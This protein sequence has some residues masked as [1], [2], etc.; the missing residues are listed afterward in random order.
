MLFLIF[1]D[2][3]E[4]LGHLLLTLLFMRVILQSE[5]RKDKKYYGFLIIVIIT[6]FLIGIQD[7]NRI[8]YLTILSL[9]NF[10]IIAVCFKGNF[11]RNGMIYFV[12]EM[13]WFMVDSFFTRILDSYKDTQASIGWEWN[14]GSICITLIKILFILLI[15]FY[16][17]KKRKEKVWSNMITRLPL[18]YY[19]I[20][21]SFLFFS[22]LSVITV[23]INEGVYGNQSL[24][25]LMAVSVGIL[26]LIFLVNG[27]V[28]VL[29]NASRCF[30]QQQN[31][32]KDEYIH[33]QNQF[34][35]EIYEG[36][37]EMR[38]FRH[39][40][41]AHI[42][43]MKKLLFDRK[44]KELED[45]MTSL[46]SNVQKTI[47]HKINSKNEM[48]DAI[49]NHLIARGGEEGVPIYILG[50]FPEKISVH[51]Y[52]L[53]AIFSNSISNAIEACKKIPI[54][55]RRHIEVKVKNF[56]QTLFISV[57]NTVHKPVDLSI[58]RNETTKR[59]SKSRGFGIGTMIETVERYGGD[60]EFK[61][62]GDTFVV[63][64]LFYDVIINKTEG[65]S[66]L[67]EGGQKITNL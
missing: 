49:L 67:E 50:N 48:V 64:I 55:Q 30:L 36:D 59:N 26:C 27:G 54:K 40:M 5:F 31:Q 28:M 7:S 38:R 42:D 60:I 6:N 33:V 23:K 52:D 15:R 24:E 39:D 10:V 43:S 17:K 9:N 18:Y 8:I 34:Y 14:I 3:V 47:R 29:L 4:I 2:I 45:Y 32:L 13:G 1:T 25:K 37:R 57:E 35:S 20:L 66:F 61:N 21:V 22:Y 62:K 41:Y 12:S 63:E 16:L 65:Y 11:L 58:L 56:R 46:Y 51:S 19:A 44:Y 53:C